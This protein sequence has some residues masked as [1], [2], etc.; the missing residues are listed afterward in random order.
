MVS[1]DRNLK[2]GSKATDKNL[3]R[4]PH[5]ETKRETL[6]SAARRPL[7]MVTIMS[8]CAE[9]AQI[10]RREGKGGR[11]GWRVQQRLG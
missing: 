9:R 3:S 2:K 8:S 4:N 5:R 7:L 11:V 10:T 1:Y 6:L